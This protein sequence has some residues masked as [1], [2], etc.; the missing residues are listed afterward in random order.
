MHKTFTPLVTP[1]PPEI[2]APPCHVVSSDVVDGSASLHLEALLQS[3]ADAVET[4]RNG[5]GGRPDVSLPL[6]LVGFSKGAVVLNQLVTELACEARRG[7]GSTRGDKTSCSGC[8]DGRRLGRKRQR[9][10]TGRRRCVACA[11]DRRRA[12]HRGES[13]PPL[14]SRTNGGYSSS[15]KAFFGRGGGQHEE[16]D[17]GDGRTKDYKSRV[18]GDAVV[19]APQVRLPRKSFL[20]A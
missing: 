5:E 8:G 2:I 18:P 13:S 11:G 3:A 9:G 10:A 19:V 1:P 17:G 7:E 6:T 15:E 16:E 4:S 14:S 20:A 12:N